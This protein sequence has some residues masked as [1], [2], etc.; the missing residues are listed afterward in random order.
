MF[1]ET[2]RPGYTGTTQVGH[3]GPSYASAHEPPQKDDAPKESCSSRSGHG[4]NCRKQPI[5]KDAA[6]QEAL[7]AADPNPQAAAV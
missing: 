1:A 7:P 5:T 6:A 3:F 2:S 4:V